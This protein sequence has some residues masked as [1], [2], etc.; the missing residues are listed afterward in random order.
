M[1]FLDLAVTSDRG[2]GAG[3]ALAGE[4]RA[5]HGALDGLGGES[6]GTGGA[7]SGGEGAERRGRRVTQEGAGARVAE[8]GSDLH[9]CFVF[10]VCGVFEVK[11][12]DPGA[13]CGLE[14]A[15]ETR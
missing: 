2:V 3:L 9:Y 10:R 1:N 7:A 4:T 12:D 6:I 13:G 11:R 14:E 5:H 15:R 8:K